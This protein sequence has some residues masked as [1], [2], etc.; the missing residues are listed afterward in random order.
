M[1]HPDDVLIRNYFRRQ[2][3]SLEVSEIE[4][5]W[6]TGKILSTDPLVLDPDPQVGLADGLIWGYPVSGRASIF[7]VLG[8]RMLPFKRVLG[9]HFQTAYNKLGERMAYAP[10]N[11]GINAPS[12]SR[13]YDKAIQAAQVTSN[14]IIDLHVRQPDPDFA[15]LN[16]CIEAGLTPYGYLL[17]THISVSAGVSPTSGMRRWA[18]VYVDTDG[19]EKVSTTGSVETT[20]PV[21]D[22]LLDNGG[23]STVA[24]LENL[25]IS[26]GWIPL[27][28]IVLDNGQTDV[29]ATTRIVRWSFVFGEI[30]SGSSSPLTTKGDI[31]GHS[32]VDARIPVGSN[33]QV[34]TA[35]STQT[36]GVKWGTGTAGSI[37]QQYLGYNTIGGSNVAMTTGTVYY[38]KITLST[39]GQLTDISAYILETSVASVSNVGC[40]VVS[41]NAGA[42]GD[43]IAMGT[44]YSNPPNLNLASGNARWLS[45]GCPIWLA[46]G[47]YWLAV[48]KQ[49]ANGVLKLYFDAVAVDYEQTNT[50]GWISD[51]VANTGVSTAPALGSNT[52]SIRGSIIS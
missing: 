42:P 8:D 30:Q 28:G 17:K 51:G 33:G 49:N 16:V 18:L 21:N 37:S 27:A 50:G 20:T 38:K 19:I 22:M 14:E 13:V 29:D 2:Q 32:S 9:K 52:Y 23:L 3:E 47:S 1:P 35:D 26:T 10:M 43:I 7:M 39:A 12:N 44:M 41:D 5:N 15:G 31:F 40:Y 34:L 24:A 25:T 46:A 36:L 6:V 48:Q 4:D 11:D 45:M